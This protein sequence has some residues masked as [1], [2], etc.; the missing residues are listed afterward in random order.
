M[1]IFFQ[2]AERIFYF[3][4][5]YWSGYIVATAAAIGLCWFILNYFFD[6]S[7]N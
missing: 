3:I 7:A 6:F 5:C 1:K 4:I 2:T